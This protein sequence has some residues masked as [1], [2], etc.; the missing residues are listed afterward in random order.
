MIFLLAEIQSIA[1]SR[2]LGSLLWSAGG[3][4]K[5]EEKGYIS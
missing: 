4:K 3:R 5:G 2:R 1:F